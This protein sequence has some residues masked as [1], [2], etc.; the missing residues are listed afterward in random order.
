M[1]GSE[2]ASQTV[3]QPA[4][5]GRAA[6]ELRYLILAVQREGSRRLAA[7]LR[8]AGLTP[9]QAEV[10]D[11]LRDRAPLSLAELGRLLVCETGSPS[12]LVDALVQRGLVARTPSPQDRRVVSLTLTEAGRE[13][14]AASAGSSEVRDAITS[15]PHRPGDRP[16]L[17]PA[18]EAHRGH[19]RRRS[20]RGP[21]PRPGRLSSAAPG[22]LC[23]PGPRG[24]A[25]I[26]P[27]RR[28][29]D[30]GQP[31]GAGQPEGVA[32][33]AAAW[34]SQTPA[35]RCT[36]L[37]VGVLGE[38]G[39]DGGEGPLRGGLVGAG[40]HGAADRRGA[41]EFRRCRPRCHRRRPAA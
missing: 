1:P 10:L 22:Q 33:G 4:R 2:P 35:P 3:R 40:Q 24:H 38:R 18:P 5:P 6:D 30:G 28:R 12:R 34:T 15:A 27:G 17:R 31:A 29:G 9:A 32:P 37:G 19:R 14:Q 21:L 11:V 13:A 16:A 41:Q 39:A 7:R 20:H 36:P 8:D 23:R 25:V 26:L